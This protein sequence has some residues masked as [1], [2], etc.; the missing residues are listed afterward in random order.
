MIKKL[1]SM[2]L[3]LI[4]WLFFCF[5]AS[6]DQEARMSVGD[7]EKVQNLA[8]AAYEGNIRTLNKNS[9]VKMED[10]LRTGADAR[11]KVQLNDGS[12]VVMGENAELTVDEF[13]Y[14]PEKERK[15]VLNALKGAL[16][17]VGKMMDNYRRQKVTVKTP[18]ATL[19]VRGTHFWVG[20][21]DGNTGVLVLDG[22]VLVNSKYGLVSLA[23][24]EGTTIKD[25]GSLSPAK[26]WGKAKKA[27]A[28]ETVQ[29]Q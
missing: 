8:E 23:P 13:V 26:Q 20:R 12:E 16:L 27:R 29:F 6:A 11:L 10:R 25:D 7:V 21:I 22:S 9:D 15:M 28:L 4:P 17:F 1:P 14:T 18:V 19:G 2:M 24:G 3:G 5:S